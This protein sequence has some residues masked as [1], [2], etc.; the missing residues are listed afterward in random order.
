V[1]D[2]PRRVYVPSGGAVSLFESAG[3]PRVLMDGP[4]GTGKTRAICQYIV[5]VCAK[6]PG[7]RV[8]ITR[9][10]RKSMTDSVL[11]TFEEKVLG[12]SH[13]AV[14]GG[15]KRALRQSY[16]FKNGSEIVTGGLDEPTRTFSA[17]YDIVVVFEAIETTQAECESL[18]RTLRNG[19]RV[20]DGVP[21]HQL[22]CDTNPGPATHWLNQLAN[23]GWFHRILSRHEDNPFLWDAQRGDWTDQGRAYISILDSLTG[24]R[25]MRLRHGKWV[26]SEGAVYPHFDPAVHVI[27]RMPNGWEAWPRYRSIDFGY[28]NP[29]SC[30]WWATDPDGRL[31][32]YR[33]IYRT[34]TLVS[35]HA[36]QIKELTGGERIGFTVAD[37]DAEDRATLADGGI[38][39]IAANKEVVRGIQLVADRLNVQPDGK[40][41]IFFLRSALVDRDELLVE[42]KAPCGTVEEFD[43][44][45][46]QPGKDGKADK[47]EPMKVHDHG[48]DEMRYMVMELDGKAPFFFTVIDHAKAPPPALTSRESLDAVATARAERERRFMM[49]ERV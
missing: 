14:L 42:K 38:D 36:K 34:R 45:I 21:V 48:M 10:T 39:T 20:V 27:D 22:I 43:C 8:L 37:H 18:L 47:E 46:W 49:G 26:S 6:Y 12:P 40:P 1:S 5:A 28:T 9:K 30:S 13:Y 29:F 35:K 3:H 32:L 7:L 33:Q 17:E 25:K 2:P 11:V 44:Y 16:K 15:P 4:A 24:A 23:S 19:K 41:R 31:Y